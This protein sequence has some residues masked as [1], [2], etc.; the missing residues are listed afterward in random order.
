MNEIKEK[1]KSF[2]TWDE[3]F[4]G[5]APVV[6]QQSVRI[7][8]YT[9]AIFVKACEAKF[10]QKQTGGAERMQITYAELAYKCGMFHQLGKAIVPAE[11]QILEP[12]F[13]PEEIALYRKYTT[14]GRSLVAELQEKSTSSKRGWRTLS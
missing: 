12:H 9:K 2:E 7:A 10:A 8:A 3:A 13:T 11:Y 14:E 5:L 1:R 6:R 4:R